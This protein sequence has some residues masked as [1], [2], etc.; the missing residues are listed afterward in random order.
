MKEERKIAL[1]RKTKETRV[2]NC[3]SR[4]EETCIEFSKSIND[5]NLYPD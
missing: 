2:Q 1:I 5:T 4:E 3:L